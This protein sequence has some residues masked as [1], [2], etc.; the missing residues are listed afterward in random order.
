MKFET[1]PHPFRK[2]QSQQMCGIFAQNEVKLI[3][4]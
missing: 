4:T 3:I 2:I 1:K